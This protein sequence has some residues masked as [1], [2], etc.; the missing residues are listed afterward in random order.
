MENKIINKCLPTLASK[1]DP[2][3]KEACEVLLQK[4]QMAL[5][6]LL[7]LLVQPVRYPK[8]KV[9]GQVR[10]ATIVCGL[11]SCLGKMFWRSLGNWFCLHE[12]KP[13]NFSQFPSAV[14]AAAF[15]HVCY[16]QRGFQRP[17]QKVATFRATAFIAINQ[18]W[19]TALPFFRRMARK[20]FMVWIMLLV[21]RPKSSTLVRSIA[22]AK[23]DMRIFL[24]ENFQPC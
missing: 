16:P 12:L 5:D 6:H 2:V 15:S 10:V 18:K 4:F 13:R 14:A 11:Q 22:F 7:V 17:N 20:N 1:D 23:Q 21:E 9:P 24:Q 19:D 8:Q 3:F